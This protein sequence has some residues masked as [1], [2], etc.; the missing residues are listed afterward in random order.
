[1]KISRRFAK[2]VTGVG[3]LLTI[4]PLVVMASTLAKY[5]AHTVAANLAQLG[6][7]A[8]SLIVGITMLPLGLAMF[9]GGYS[10]LML[11]KKT[12]CCSDEKGHSGCCGSGHE[13]KHEGEKK[14]GCCSSEKPDGEKH[15]C[16]CSGN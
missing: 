3:L 7:I 13:H 5:S 9:I 6:L 4:V 12:G 10:V 16:G 2:T 8:W 14:E 15:S 11:Q 1:M